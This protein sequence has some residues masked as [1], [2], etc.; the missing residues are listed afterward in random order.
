M[1]GKKRGKEGSKGKKG[2]LLGG[3]G[4]EEGEVTQLLLSGRCEKT[5]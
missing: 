4:R 3:R 2:A 5:G 1:M